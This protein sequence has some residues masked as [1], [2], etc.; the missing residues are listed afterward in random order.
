[1]VRTR[2]QAGAIALA[3][4]VASSLAL[5]LVGAPSAQRRRQRVAGSQLAC[6]PRTST[7]S[8]APAPRTLPRH[9]A[10]RAVHRTARTSSTGT[11]RRHVHRGHRLLARRR[12]LQLRRRLVD[13]SGP[14]ARC[15]VEPSPAT[16][17]YAFTNDTGETI[18]SLTV[19]YVGE[20][21]RFGG[22][23][24]QPRRADVRV[25]HRRHRSGDRHVHRPSRRWR[26]PRR[27][28]PARRARSTATPRPTAPSSPSTISGLNV[29]AG[30]TVVLRWTD[31]DAVGGGDDGLAVDDLAVA[32]NGAA[33]PN[34]A[35]RAVLRR[36]VH[37]R[38][39]HR[40]LAA[41]R[42]HRS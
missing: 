14:R 13:R 11:A 21:W 23:A 10:R 29:A 19:R 33:L 32:A 36:H 39:R 37:R 31:I 12:H 16:L 2:F 41:D 26:S 28:P 3:T 27:S 30:A 1:M 20:Q 17:G 38:R 6:S 18:T 15:A 34:A 42:G 7:A 5:V 22:A 24:H 4:F 40:R 9:A 8:S 35:D 25:Q